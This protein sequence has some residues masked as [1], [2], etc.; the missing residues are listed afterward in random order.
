M[1]LYS[2]SNEEPDGANPEAVSEASKLKMVNSVE[3]RNF[4]EAFKDMLDERARSPHDNRS[5][6]ISDQNKHLML[7]ESKALLA[8]T[9]NESELKNDD[10]TIVE[11]A[12]GVYAAQIQFTN[13]NK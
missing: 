9:G 3:F 4:K 10:V 6:L 13:I 8:L 2:C 12:I 7:E 5:P 11:K 1:G